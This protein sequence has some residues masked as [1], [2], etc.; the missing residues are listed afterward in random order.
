MVNFSVTIYKY[1]VHKIIFIK[2][3]KDMA[4]PVVFDGV[5]IKPT[6]FFF[7][8][9]VLVLPYIDMNPPQVYMSSQS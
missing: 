9:T 1:L 6:I 4:F 5:F 7:I 3:E 2:M 8:F